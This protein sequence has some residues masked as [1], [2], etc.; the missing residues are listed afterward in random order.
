M[1]W[2]AGAGLGVILVA[3]AASTTIGV[4]A[5]VCQRW[6][7]GLAV[8]F[9]AIL[10]AAYIPT[11]GVVAVMIG[12]SRMPEVSAEPAEKARVLGETISSLMN[13]SCWGLPLGV[14]LGVARIIPQAD[15]HGAAQ[16]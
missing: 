16:G 10:V 7:E 13:L 9:G 14:A 3:S 8:V 11:L 12:P 15:C 2:L 5:L 1:V 6:R 4:W